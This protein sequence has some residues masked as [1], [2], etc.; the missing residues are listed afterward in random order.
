[1]SPSAAQAA[2]WWQGAVLITYIQKTYHKK[3]LIE[4][5]NPSKKEKAIFFIKELGSSAGT[6]LPVN[7]LS[8]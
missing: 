3:G 7:L 5:L 1:M 2:E 6:F 4:W 8:D